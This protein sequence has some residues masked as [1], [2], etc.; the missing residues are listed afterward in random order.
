MGGEKIAVQ[1]NG[2]R[3][4]GSPPRGRGK[5]THYNEWLYNAGITPA[6]AGKSRSHS[7][8]KWRWGDHPRVG[9]EK[10]GKGGQNGMSEGSPPRGRG[11][12]HLTPTSRNCR[13]ITPAWAGKRPSCRQRSCRSRDHP[14][15]GG[16]KSHTAPIVRTGVGSPPRGRGKDDEQ[17]ATYF[18][19]RITP[20]WAG[21]RDPPL[22][23]VPI[24]EDHPRVGGEKVEHTAVHAAVAGSPPRGRGKAG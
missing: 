14:R 16:E 18:S 23:P 5:V 10:Q 15:V 8:S 19:G 21:K 1:K 12:G 3:K 20:A 17:E 24:D 4:R 6:W 13:R 22:L 7:H 9:G 2:T 11:K